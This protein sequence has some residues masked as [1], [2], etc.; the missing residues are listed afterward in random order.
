MDPSVFNKMKSL[1]NQLFETKYDYYNALESLW[2]ENWFQ[3]LNDKIPEGVDWS[4]RIYGE[5]I[6]AYYASGYCGNFLVIIPDTNIVAL[7]CADAKGF[8]YETGYFQ[9]FVRLV[10]ELVP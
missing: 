7:R 6:V 1:K 8:N 4:K 10:S 2:G 5:E 9:E 3:L